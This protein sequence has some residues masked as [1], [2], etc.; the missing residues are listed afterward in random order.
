VEFLRVLEFKRGMDSVANLLSDYPI[1]DL[2]LIL[3][4]RAVYIHYSRTTNNHSM[5]EII[6]TEQLIE[7]FEEALDILIPTELTPGSLFTLAGISLYDCGPYCLLIEE[8]ARGSFEASRPER[9]STC[10][11]I[12]LSEV[13]SSVTE[14]SEVL[15]DD[16]NPEVRG[17][18]SSEL[19]QLNALYLSKF[20]KQRDQN[21]DGRSSQ[22]ASSSIMP[23]G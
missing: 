21:G 19:K 18:P 22:T 23:E 7:C 2:V 14:F 20:R 1:M 10:E 6:P 13:G 16:W 9:P 4:V 12:D 17:N 15:C 3:V 11:S 5:R 8:R